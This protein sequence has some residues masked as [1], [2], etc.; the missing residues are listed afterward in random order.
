MHVYCSRFL[1][2]QPYSKKVIAPEVVDTLYGEGEKASGGE[3]DLSM[4]ENTQRLV[5]HFGL[6]VFD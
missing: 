3:G 2:C 4:L 6:T 5:Q 1:A